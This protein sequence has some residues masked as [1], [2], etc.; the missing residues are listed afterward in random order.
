MIAVR[1]N[2][3]CGADGKAGDAVVNFY[4]KGGYLIH[5]EEFVGKLSKG[6]SYER[7]IDIDYDTIV[8]RSAI[9]SGT[10]EYEVLVRV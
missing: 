6:N 2:E 3:M 9:F 1:V 7:V 5:S 8:S 10:F 4:G